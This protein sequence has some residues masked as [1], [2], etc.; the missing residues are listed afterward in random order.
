MSYDTDYHD[1]RQ[2]FRDLREELAA[3]NDQRFQQLELQQALFDEI[4]IRHAGLWDAYRDDL[5]YHRQLRKPVHLKL[6]TGP[7][8]REYGDRWKLE[9]LGIGKADDALAHKV[10]C[11]FAAEHGVTLQS[12]I[13]EARTAVND[14]LTRVRQKWSTLARLRLLGVN[15]ELPSRSNNDVT[16]ADRYNDATNQSNNDVRLNRRDR[17][18]DVTKSK[19]E[20]SDVDSPAKP[21]PVTPPAS[22]AFL[23]QGA[24]H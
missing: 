10:G 8:S 23:Q 1:L 13:G 11:D 20:Q 17:H 22:L 12:A 16:S 2:D 4:E 7:L 5:E 21:V 19:S 15:V 18:N 14:Q 3:E 6:G 24:A 9:Y